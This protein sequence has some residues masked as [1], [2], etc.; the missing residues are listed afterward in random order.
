[1]FKEK[2]GAHALLALMRP[3]AR[4]WLKNALS[5]Q[6]FVRIGKH[7]FV[8]EAR[9]ALQREGHKT[10]TSRISVL[11]GIDRT[12][13]LRIS[14][15]PADA[16]EAPVGI[17]ERVLGQWRQDSRFI[18]SHGKPRILK[19]SGEPQEFRALVETVTKTINAGT[20]LA[21]FKRRGFVE[22]TDRG[23]KLLIQVLALQ[24]D[25]TAG[26]ELMARDCETLFETIQE[27]L[28]EQPEISNLHIRTEYDNVV[29]SQLPKIRRW[30]VN[31]GKKFHKKARNFISKYDKDITPL[32]GE[33][34]GGGRV[35]L[36]AYSLTPK[37]PEAK[38]SVEKAAKRRRDRGAAKG[39]SDEA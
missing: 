37:A 33:I 35:I 14:D 24:A 11:T 21:E 15:E 8:L 36:T 2:I 29:L 23:V 30:L 22:Q 10:N 1:M 32:K 27:N 17:L 13:I 26:V 34:G 18:D 20:V 9:E 4:F 5:F 28:F 7:A 19:C 25:K 38:P 39:N 16:S 3:L 12:E 6:D 31:E